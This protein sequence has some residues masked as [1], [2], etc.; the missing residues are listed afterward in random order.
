MITVNL[1]G[2]IGSLRFGEHN[3]E[4]VCNV[5]VAAWENNK[6]TWFSVA[7]WGQQQVERF[8]AD[9][10]KAGT[11]FVGE[12]KNLCAETYMSR[13]GTYKAQLR[14]TAQRFRLVNPEAKPEQDPVPDATGADDVPF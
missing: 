10:I 5:S 2:R 12:C 8:E 1:F 3:G 7:V 6:T 14:C 13:E 11:I 9:D 4:R